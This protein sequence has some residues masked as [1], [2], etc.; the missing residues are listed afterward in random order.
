VSGSGTPSQDPYKPKELELRKRE[1][2]YAGLGLAIQ[3]F[4]VLF[5]LV[6]T[7]AAAYAAVQAANAVNVAAQGMEQQANAD[8]LSTA[9]SAIGGDQAAERVGGFALLRRH[10]EDR[11]NTA[12]TPEERLDAYN[13]YTSALE[14]LVNY[15]RNPSEASTAAKEPTAGLGFGRP[16]IPY[17]NK[18]A[19]RELQSLMRLKPEIQELRGSLEA[20]AP[21]PAVDLFEVQLF[22]QSWAGI[23]F[24]WL[25]GHYFAGIDLRGANLR[26]SVWGES[27]LEGAHLQCA[28]LEG[29][30][31]RGTNLIG[32]DLRGAHLYDAD[33]TDAKLDRVKLDGATFLEKA[34]GLDSIRPRP[35]PGVSR[36]DDGIGQDGIEECL[37]SD[38]S[39][40]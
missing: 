5:A 33:F 27:S 10:V 37:N 7:G 26:H 40:R 16:R 11:V 2:R 18:Y 21:P 13:L 36:A 35:K 8:R 20:E 19:A 39:K 23:D 28:N 32:A 25:G 1:I 14:V 6:A 4:L 24:A 15:L 34:K 9:I 12:D 29:A 22:Q 3:F 31:L 38:Y 17:D 30:D